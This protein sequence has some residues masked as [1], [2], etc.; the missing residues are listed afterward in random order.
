M[1]K[2]KQIQEKLT[3]GEDFSKLAQEFSDDIGSAR[4]SGDL[5]YFGRGVM[6]KAF[7][8]VAFKLKKGEISEPVRSRFGYHLIRLDDIREAQLVKLDDV[9]ESIRHDL[10]IQQAEQAFYESVDK[11]NN[12]SYENPRDSLVPVAESLGL[13]LKKSPLFTREGGSRLFASPR[14]VSVAFSDEVLA[15]GRNSQLIELSDTH[16]LVLRMAEHVPVKQQLLKDVIGLVKTRLQDEKVTEK[17][18]A[19]SAAA[20]EQLRA[21]VDPE[22][23]ARSLKAE[24]K[25]V[26]P[27]SRVADETSLDLDP[28]I[29]HELFHMPRPAEGEEVYKDTRLANG[30][31]AV[32]VLSAVIDGKKYTDET[33]L[34]EKRKLIGVYGQA[35]Q[36][37]WMAE[38]RNNA[39]I[40]TNLDSLE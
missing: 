24:W 28:Q 23:L 25:F 4:Q 40:T 30:D 27:V 35:M 21:G 11:L 9:K 20:L 15:E 8:D 37:A 10:Q 3:A 5:G 16:V 13:E 34:T 19:D 33:S 7:E 12:L 2:L 17:I 26:G 31:A 36:S 22:K 14:L 6:D 32:L 39:D 29:R 18:K 38:L 1:D